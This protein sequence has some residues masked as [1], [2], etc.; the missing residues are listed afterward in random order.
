MHL[1]MEANLSTHQ[2]LMIL[3]WWTYLCLISLST[4]PVLNRQEK[5]TVA[6]GTASTGQNLDA[7]SQKW[8]NNKKSA[9]IAMLFMQEFF[10]SWKLSKQKY[11]IEKKTSGEKNNLFSEY[12]INFLP[13]S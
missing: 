1:G 3:V 6:S 7:L 8:L 5:K 10:M 13:P 2:G 11:V 12:L 9:G 4:F